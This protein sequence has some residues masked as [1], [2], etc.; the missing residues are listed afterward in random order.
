MGAQGKLRG[1]QRKWG[2]MGRENGWKINGAVRMDNKDGKVRY[3]RARK[4]KLNQRGRWYQ[5]VLS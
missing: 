5:Y 3:R 1:Q 2:E 4:I